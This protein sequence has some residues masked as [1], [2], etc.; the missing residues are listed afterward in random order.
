MSISALEKKQCKFILTSVA[1]R[2]KSHLMFPPE[3][4]IVI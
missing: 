3:M 2:D 1:I 4:G